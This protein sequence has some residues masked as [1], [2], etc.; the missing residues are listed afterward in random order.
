M[1]WA[2][3]RSATGK[4]KWSRGYFWPNGKGGLYLSAGNDQKRFDYCLN[5][6]YIYRGIKKERGERVINVS[7]K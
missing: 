4:R 5:L 2:F 6:W 1:N 7:C 3:Q